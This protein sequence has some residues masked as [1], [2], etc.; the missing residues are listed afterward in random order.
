MAGSHRQIQAC[1]D[2]DLVQPTVAL[3]KHGDFE[4]K[5]EAAWYFSFS[6]SPIRHALAGCSPTPLPEPI[7]IKSGRWWR[8]ASFRVCATC[9]RWRT[10]KS[11]WSAL[12]LSV[13]FTS[14]Q[15]A[16]EGLDN[17][18]RATKDTGSKAYNEL[19]EECGGLDKIEA[20]Q[21]HEN[22]E[23]YKR[24]LQLLKDYF[25]D[26]DQENADPQLQPTAT[27]SAFTFGAAPLK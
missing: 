19:I 25:E 21:R 3:A 10:P 12:V 27:S 16:L 8:P 26:A 13:V 18:L 1:I 22:D 2:A 5:K 14:A 15:V 20:L 6:C 24:A 9:W 11:C 17:I 4:V 7:S 23:V